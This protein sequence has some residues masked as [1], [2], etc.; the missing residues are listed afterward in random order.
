[1]K[2]GNSRLQALVLVIALGAALAA[3]GRSG[4]AAGGKDP[5]VQL[6]AHIDRM[7]AILKD[8]EADPPKAIRELTAYQEKNKAEI[9]R[10]KQHLGDF[11]QKDPMKAA[12][13]S[14][15]YGMRSAELD[16]RTHELEAKAA[17]R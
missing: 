15:V 8:N 6:L 17:A 7:I 4:G 5:N 1:M 3:C 11:M 14:S 16:S 9:E 2:N 13:V 10:L 12:A